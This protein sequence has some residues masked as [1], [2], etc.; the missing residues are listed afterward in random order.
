VYTLQPEVYGN[1]ISQR[2]SGTTSFYLFDGLGSTTQLAN[3]TGSATD[4]YLYDSFGNIL[5]ASGT[6]T[7]W[8][9]YIGQLGYYYDID[10]AK[11]YI[12]ART[13][14]PASGRFLS[15]DPIGLRNG[16]ITLYDYVRSNPIQFTDPSGSQIVIPLPTPVPI[17]VPIP[18]IPGP[19][20]VVL[21]GACFA[22]GVYVG[23]CIGE[24]TTGPLVRWWC[25]PRRIPPI[26]YKCCTYNCGGKIVQRTWLGGHCSKSFKL[27]D[28]PTECEFV[29]EQVGPCFSPN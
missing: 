4:S 14:D 22:G 2:R 6:T 15:R 18:V 12:R 1:L 29:S 21:G 19:P 24:Y 8:F 17:P 3:S 28:P 7:N 16:G 23:Y 11:Y 27:L 20:P 25:K 9:R 5:L 13:Y 10:L 26:K